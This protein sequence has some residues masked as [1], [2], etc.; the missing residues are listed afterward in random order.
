MQVPASALSDMNVSL[1]SSP[2]N[3]LKWDLSSRGG[4]MRHDLTPVGW[5]LWQQRPVTGIRLNR[6]EMRVMSGWRLGCVCG[7]VGG[8]WS[9]GLVRANMS[10]HGQMIRCDASPGHV[11]GTCRVMTWNPVPR[12]WRALDCLHN[13]IHWNSTS[14]CSLQLMLNFS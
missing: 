2:N 13:H 8:W 10:T 9:S 6:V 1:H 7:G 12:R 14:V 11:E 5:W 3:P 4:W